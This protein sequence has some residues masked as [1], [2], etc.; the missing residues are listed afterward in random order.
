MSD[1][2]VS[3]KLS[4]DDAKVKATFSRVAAALDDLGPL[5]DDLGSSQVTEVQH[6]FEEQEGPDGKRWKPLAAS[7]L[8]RRGPSAKILRD[9][10]NLYDSI[11]HEPD[12]KHGAVRVGSNKVYARIHQLGGDAGKGKKVKIPARPYLGVSGE[13]LKEMD[14]IAQSYMAKAV[15]G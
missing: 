13:G 10:A 8:A 9:K 5:L 12:A 3:I 14:R 11:T 2:G 6:R 4:V 7:T 15:E 1:E